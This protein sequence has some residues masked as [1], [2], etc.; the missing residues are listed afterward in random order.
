MN[1]CERCGM[2]TEEELKPFQYGIQ[3]LRICPECYENLVYAQ[4]TRE[5]GESDDSMSEVR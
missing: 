4:S 5:K 2:E 1:K 3:P